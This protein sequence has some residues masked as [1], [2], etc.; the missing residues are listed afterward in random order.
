[1]S[2]DGSQSEELPAVSGQSLSPDPDELLHVLS[3]AASRV[4]QRRFRVVLLIRRAYERMTAH[5]SLLTA[6]WDDLQTMMRLLLRW[7]DRSY[8][9]VSWTPL[10]LI[11]GALLYFITPLDLVPDAL[12]ALGFVDDATVITTVVQRIRG[13]L[14][15]FRA[16]EQRALPE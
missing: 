2:D 14:E 9:Q 15:R 11:V 16:W 6:V 13:E 1:M 7:A 12:G 3:E 4:L 8:R 10:L 5:A